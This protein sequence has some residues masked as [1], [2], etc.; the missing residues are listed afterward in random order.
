MAIN[1]ATTAMKLNFLEEAVFDALAGL[2]EV[3]QEIIKRR[4]GLHGESCM[5]YEE[6]AEYLSATLSP[7]VRLRIATR[8]A[9]SD[10][11]GLCEEDV[12]KLESEGL[13]ELARRCKKPQP[14][15]S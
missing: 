15:P 6:L 12:K 8:V 1:T 7:E 14:L 9:S 10:E 11:A 5:T 3:K 13:R 4:F 2:D